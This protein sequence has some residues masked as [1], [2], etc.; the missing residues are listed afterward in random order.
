[1]SSTYF[2]SLGT[3]FFGKKYFQ[4]IVHAEDS[5]SYWYSSTIFAGILNCAFVMVNNNYF[6]I[7]SFICLRIGLVKLRSIIYTSLSF[8]SGIPTDF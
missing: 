8:V 7:F 6:F 3:G 4:A 5:P 2:N 1:M